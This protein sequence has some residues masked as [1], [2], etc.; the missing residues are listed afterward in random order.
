MSID[1]DETPTT[2][3]KRG[4]IVFL[5]AIFIFVFTVLAYHQVTAVDE[6]PVSNPNVMHNCGITSYNKATSILTYHCGIED[7]KLYVVKDMSGFKL[8][9][10]RDCEIHF[11]DN[12]QI[13][14]MICKEK[15]ERIELFKNTD[16]TLIGAWQCTGLDGFGGHRNE[17]IVKFNVIPDG[18]FTI[19]LQAKEATDSVWHITDSTIRGTFRQANGN[20]I[21]FY[22]EEWTSEVIQRS[23]LT[24]KD[25]PRFMPSEP[26]S[27]DVKSLARAHFNGP[28]QRLG[29]DEASGQVNCSKLD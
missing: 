10:A 15:D 25:A 18:R 7:K 17:N 1:I 23:G 26:F 4:T 6:T 13:D 27:I 2:T 14:S 22:P 3:N 8:N 12:G 9:P 24:L 29:Y 19:E 16:A 11:A 28:Y 5:T 20:H 21:E